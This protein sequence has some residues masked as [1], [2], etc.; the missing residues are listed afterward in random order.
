MKRVF[1]FGEIWYILE[2][3]KANKC[4]RGEPSVRHSIKQVVKSIIIGGENGER[5]EAEKE[6]EAKRGGRDYNRRAR[7]GYCVYWIGMWLFISYVSIFFAHRLL[8]VEKD[9]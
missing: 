1:T 5:E 8:S 2:G 4:W 9:T 7:R 3:S 6:E